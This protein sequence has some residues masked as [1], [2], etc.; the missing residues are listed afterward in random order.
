MRN[1]LKSHIGWISK[2]VDLKALNFIRERSIKT[3]SCRYMWVVN[4]VHNIVLLLG[5]NH[6]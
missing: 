1:S 4:K 5:F 3:R 6:F 2:A